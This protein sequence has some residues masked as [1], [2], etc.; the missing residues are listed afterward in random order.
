MGRRRGGDNSQ[1]QFCSAA[2]APKEFWTA[3]HQKSFP[4]LNVQLGKKKTEWKGASCYFTTLARHHHPSP[5][6][7]C[8][9]RDSQREQVKDILL[10]IPRYIIK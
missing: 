7:S 10:Q 4:P 3:A 6:V 8:C 1:L 2:A 5:E 9:L